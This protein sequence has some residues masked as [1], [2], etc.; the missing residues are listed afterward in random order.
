LPQPAKL[1]L[2][3]YCVA[4]TLQPKLG[5]ELPGQAT[6]YDAALDFTGGDMSGYWR[7]GKDDFLS[8]ISR[9]QLLLLARE[10]LGGDWAQLRQK[11][12]KASLVDQLTRAFADPGKHGRTRVQVEKLKR[13]LPA[14]MGFAIGP[15]PKTAKKAAKAA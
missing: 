15:A 10:T 9:E 11:D 13:W 1:K 14:G 12:K 3:A 6:A 2:L 8:R 4:M 7:P 5:P